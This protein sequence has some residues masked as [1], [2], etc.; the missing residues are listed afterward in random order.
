V[1]SFIFHLID[2]ATGLLVLIYLFKKQNLVQIWFHLCFLFI[3]SL[4][5]VVI[6]IINF[7]S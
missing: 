7:S 6:F 5:S 2:L 4:V 3:N 1:L